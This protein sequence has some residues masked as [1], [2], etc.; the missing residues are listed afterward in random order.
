MNIFTHIYNIKSTITILYL[1][2]VSG[3]GIK[4]KKERLNK[5]MPREKSWTLK[6]KMYKT[7]VSLI[8]ISRK[9]FIKSFGFNKKV[10]DS[11]LCIG[12]TSNI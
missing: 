11:V 4:K 10:Y 1:F 12:V 5:L 7:M 2:S 3:S 8:F 9:Y 6:M